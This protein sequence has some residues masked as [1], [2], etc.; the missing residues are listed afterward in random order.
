M[1]AFL[2]L[3]MKFYLPVSKLQILTFSHTMTIVGPL[4]TTAADIFEKLSPWRRELNRGRHFIR[5]SRW[6]NVVDS[7]LLKTYKFKE[8]TVFQL[9]HWKLECVFNNCLNTNEYPVDVQQNLHEHDLNIRN[10]LK[11]IKILPLINSRVPLTIPCYYLRK[12]LEIK[13]DLLQT[14]LFLFWASTALWFSCYQFLS[15]F[16]FFVCLSQPVKIWWLRK[17][18][19]GGVRA[20][21]L[22]TTPSSGMRGGLRRLKHETCN[23]SGKWMVIHILLLGIKSNRLII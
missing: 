2:Q 16:S 9:W 18:T 17:M 13:I 20:V 12:N 15:A 14:N 7:C 6:K 22:H 23:Y 10:S 1:S 8:L 5:R 4:F 19:C 3:R 11:I 21:S